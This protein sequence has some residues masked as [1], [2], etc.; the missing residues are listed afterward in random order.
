[1]LRNEQD[2]FIIG[3]NCSIINTDIPDTD[4]IPLYILQCKVQS[5]TTC[6]NDHMQR[7]DQLVITVNTITVAIRDI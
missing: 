6:R 7:T 4:K 1:M 5:V 3:D 2:K